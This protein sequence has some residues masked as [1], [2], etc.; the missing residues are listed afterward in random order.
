MWEEEKLSARVP[1]YARYCE[2]SHRKNKPLYTYSGIYFSIPEN[3]KTFKD[4][5]KIDQI[6]P[7][8]VKTRFVCAST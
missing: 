6:R 8:T 7:K 4:S 1:K 5:I 3:T 2:T